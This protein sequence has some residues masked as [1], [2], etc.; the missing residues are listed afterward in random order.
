LGFALV[1][2][3]GLGL[4][5]A[6]YVWDTRGISYPVAAVLGLASVL[7]AALAPQRPLLAWRLGYLT[8]FVGAL[9]VRPAE[10]WPWNPVQLIGMVFVLIVVAAREP[11]GVVVWIAL[12]GVVPVAAFVHDNPGG[13]ALVVVAMLI[14]ERVGH[15]RQNRAALAEQEQLTQLEQARRAVLEERARIAREMHDVVAHHMSMIAVQAETAPYRL[16]GLS[17]PAQAELAA[18]AAGAR[19]ALADMRRLLGVLR[20]DAAEAPRSPQPGLA[21]LP[22]L[23]DTVR[24]AGLRV[25]LELAARPGDVPPAVQLAAYRIVQEA[26]ANAARHAPDGPVRVRLRAGDA[27][28]DLRARNALPDPV[29]PAG[30]PGHGLVGM[31]ERAALLGGTL[32]AGPDDAGGYVVTA[33][34]PYDGAERPR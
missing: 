21:E 5:A 27:A 18:I 2:L 6:Q 34:L 30:P 15:R 13:Y 17:E 28:L 19:A 10:P 9:G 11:L 3:F 31:H 7:P 22:E 4:A 1:A 25:D 26:L 24:R 32:T 8:L 23:V 12:W 33:T 16:A 20:S 14:A 29:P